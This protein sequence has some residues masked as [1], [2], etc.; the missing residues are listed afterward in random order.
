[1]KVESKA[2][3][4]VKIYMDGMHFIETQHG[5]IWEALKLEQRKHVI[6]SHLSLQITKRQGWHSCVCV[7]VSVKHKR[8]R[9]SMTAN[10]FACICDDPSLLLLCYPTNSLYT[11]RSY[12]SHTLTT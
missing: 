12:Q 5:G 4:S 10:G 11:L 8:L 7:C 2:R 6:S 3:A 9:N 1:M